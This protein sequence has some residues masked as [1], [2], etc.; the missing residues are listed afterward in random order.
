MLQQKDIIIKK[1]LV[2]TIS[3]LMLIGLFFCAQPLLAVTLDYQ[4][5]DGDDDAF[6]TGDDGAVVEGD[7]QLKIYS[8]TPVTSPNYRYGGFRWQN[9]AIP[10]GA[11]ITDAWISIYPNEP[12]NDDINVDIHF[13][14]ADFPANFTGVAYSLSNRSKT[15]D[16]VPWVADNLTLNTWHNSNSLTDVIQE[17]VDGPDWDSGDPLVALFIPIVGLSKEVRAVAYDSQDPNPDGPTYAA[18]LHIEYTS[19]G[20]TDPPTPDPMTFVTAPDDASTTSI[21]MTATTASDPSTPVEYRFT[22]TACGADPGTGGTSSLW[23]TSTSYTDTGLQVNQC[24]GYT[25]TARDSVPNTGTAS[26][27]SEAYTAAAVP[28]T[29]TLDGATASTL[30]LTNA[31]NGNPS[32][33]PTT[34]FAVQVVT[35]TPNDATWLNKW[36][37]ASGN[38]S[39]SEVWMTDAQLDALT[40]QGL[41]GSTTY[42]VRVKA[43]NGDGDETALSPRGECSNHRERQQRTGNSR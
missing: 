4:V 13:E 3:G 29:P 16:S 11:T 6:E 36:V 20:D 33:N 10:A 32:A 24:Y 42:G 21:D 5:G 17:V 39:A 37:D 43:K 41:N 7:D 8:D 15:T 38:P 22:Y 40:L 25:V 27:S 26:S 30:D 35:T 14:V 18:K 9:V 31:E 1:K 12:G 23:Q 28:G 2:A 34:T 19:G